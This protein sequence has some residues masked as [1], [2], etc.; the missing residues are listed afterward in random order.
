MGRILG[1]GLGVTRGAHV[2]LKTCVRG[3]HNSGRVAYRARVDQ[4][5]VSRLE[6][7]SDVEDCQVTT[8]GRYV[9]ALGGKLKLGAQF[10]NKRIVIA[11]AQKRALSRSAQRNT[12]PTGRKSARG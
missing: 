11:G 2:S 1:R 9:E 3:W 8:L 5:D 4:S 10:G 7:R 6:V 12:L